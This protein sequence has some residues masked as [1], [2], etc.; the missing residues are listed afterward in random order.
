MKRIS[1]L[2][3]LAVAM[4]L[5]S[6]AVSCSVDES[7][8][9][10]RSAL[11]SFSQDTVSFDTV[12][13][14]VGS[15]TQNI[16]VFNNQNE[17][18]RISNIRLASGG[19]SGFRVNV[20]GM[21]G[22]D[23]SDVE[24]HSNDSMYV[25]VELTADMTG[26]QEPVEIKDSL[27][28]TLESGA[29]QKVLLMASAQDAEVCRGL[30]VDGDT[31]LSSS[32]PYLIYDSL[33]V[34]EGATLRIAEGVRLFFHSGAGLKVYG[35]LEVNGSVDKPVVM[36]GDRTDRLLWYL[37]YDRVNAQW[38]GIRICKSSN[39][40]IIENADIHSGNYG[41]I[42]D[43]SGVEKSKLLLRNSIVHNVTKHGI[44][45][46]NNTIEVLNSQITNAG[47]DCVHIEG[48]RCRFVHCTLAQFYPWSADRGVALRFSA[49]ERTPLLGCDFVNCIIT[50]IG[51]DELMGIP[52]KM[53][54]IPFDYNFVGC[55]IRTPEV[56]DNPRF[57]EIVWDN[58]MLAE[59][60][61][62]PKIDKSEKQIIQAANFRN[63]DHENFVYDFHLDSLSRARGRAVM[64]A[65]EFLPYDKD[66]VERVG[67]PDIGCYQYKK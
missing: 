26:K 59:K 22:T 23:F 16:R 17:G 62:I 12:F 65:T 50:G 57:A 19:T 45:S 25:F 61:G 30:V 14:S 15:S 31:T 2:L 20:D 10:D 11:L 40:N 64:E 6:V 39:D 32:K 28:F 21:M 58:E 60:P 56:K 37:P 49:D 41:I 55:L 18:I 67:K 54:E 34:A 63:I 9:T 46:K 53:P 33:C 36:R 35:R 48:G 7:F 44:F 5:A 24:I 38:E 51:K 52:P 27:I 4:L 13:T 3:S 42:C 1:F 8:T 47:G 29:M 66:G 43:S